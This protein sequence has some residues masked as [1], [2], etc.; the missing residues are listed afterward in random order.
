[1]T[2]SA[3]TPCSDSKCRRHWLVT[4]LSVRI[5]LVWTDN[6]TSMLSVKGNQRTG[7]QIRLHRMFQDAPDTI[8]QAL[9]AYIRR[10]D[11]SA[12]R[13]LRTY[14]QNHRHLIL[15]QPAQRQT[16]QQVIQPRGQHFDLEAIYQNLNHRYFDNRV[17]AYITWAR[18]APQHSRV[19]IRLGSYHAVDR[20]IRI[21][22]LLDQ[23]FVP[24]YMVENVVFHEML[25]EHIPRQ[26][27]NGRWRL[28]SPEFRQAEQRFPYHQQAEQWQQ[29]NLHRLLR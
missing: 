10:T 7:Y 15:R 6:R 23:A 1:M 26:F 4:Q 18:R 14:I 13:R 5:T 22:R 21:H 2:R 9:A 25:H 8:W 24:P 16:Y 17:Q 29:R 11:K 3:L 20:L 12:L 27:V 19:S 28:H